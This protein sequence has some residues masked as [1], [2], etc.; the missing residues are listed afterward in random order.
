MER[1]YRRWP[2]AHSRA[3]PLS[4][5]AAATISFQNRV[6]RSLAALFF[7]RLA[8]FFMKYLYCP[9]RRLSPLRIIVLGKTENKTSWC[10]DS[11][12]LAVSKTKKPVFGLVIK[13][14]QFGQRPSCAVQ[15]RFLRAFFDKSKGGVFCAHS[16]AAT[17][18]QRSPLFERSRL[19]YATTLKIGPFI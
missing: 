11:R 5:L 16:S 2:S 4:P 15:E 10:A 17:T 7:S 9:V 6:A 8:Q 13:A 14:N 19:C 1:D 18:R 3:A 12:T